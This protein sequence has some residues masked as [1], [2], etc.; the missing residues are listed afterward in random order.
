VAVIEVE[1]EPGHWADRVRDYEI[2][3]DGTVVGSIGAGQRGEFAVSAGDHEIRARSD[4]GGSAT[5]RASLSEAEELK[6][7][8]RPALANADL[9]RPWRV[10]RAA[11]GGRD[12]RIRLER[13]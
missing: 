9:W 10:V 2:V 13:R 3:I 5:V 7:V 6:L 11:T 12:E 1:R 8:C 4:W